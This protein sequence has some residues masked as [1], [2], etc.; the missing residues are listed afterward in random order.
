MICYRSQNKLLAFQLKQITTNL[1]HDLLNS[2]RLANGLVYLWSLEQRFLFAFFKIINRVSFIRFLF[3]FSIQFN[4]FCTIKD[5]VGYVLKTGHQP[6][7]QRIKLPE[8]G[9][10]RN[11][12]SNR[13]RFGIRVQEFNV[14]TLPI[15]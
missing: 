2:L 13:P 14:G 12:S 9:S 3:F 5:Y 10:F 4:H 1:F 8:Q 6:T 15:F 7:N 11:R